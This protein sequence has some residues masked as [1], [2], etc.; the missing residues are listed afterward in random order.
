MTTATAFHVGSNGDG[1]HLL[2]SDQ[3]DPLQAQHESTLCS[4]EA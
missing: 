1:G 4:A 3:T 2:Q